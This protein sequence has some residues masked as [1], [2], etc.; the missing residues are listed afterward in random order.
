MVGGP[1]R[2]RAWSVPLWMGG[3]LG[4]DYPR[5]LMTL[6]ALVNDSQDNTL[7]ACRFWG[8][9]A[10]AEG[11]GRVWIVEQNFGTTADN[12]VR[13]DHRDYIAFGKV[14][15]TWSALLP[16]DCEW[17]WSVDSDIQVAPDTLRR[18]VE[19]AVEHDAKMLS[20]VIDNSQGGGCAHHTNVMEYWPEEQYYWHIYEAQDDREPGI[21]SCDLTGA[22]C[23]LHRDIFAAGCR[24]HRPGINL[25]EDILFCEDVRAAGF[26]PQYA[27]S[28][29]AMHWMKAPEQLEYLADPAWH[30][31]LAAFHASE[32]ARLTTEGSHVRQ[33]A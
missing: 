31:R 15:D 18:L 20:A 16:A 1:I 25:P 14:R 11:F 17:A 4:S 33:V 30:R 24:Y 6:C 19:L 7:E 3:L 27:P 21:K 13:D 29:R 32:A 22:C 23:L 2:E 5:E 8:E 28:V 9:L 12:N 26:Q 10:R